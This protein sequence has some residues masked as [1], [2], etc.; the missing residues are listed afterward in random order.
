MPVA[1]VC[2]RLL[3]AAFASALCAAPLFAQDA[4]ITAIASHNT[5]D[6]AFVGDASGRVFYCSRLGGCSQLEGTPVS[7]VTTMDIPRQ[8]IT[9]MRAWVGFEDGSVYYCTVTGG[10]AEQDF[11]ESTGQLLQGN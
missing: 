7:A 2:R 5:R 6:A 10:C 9:S 4:A 3:P 8:G 1:P 11:E